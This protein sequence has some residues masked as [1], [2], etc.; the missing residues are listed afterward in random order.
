MK[1]IYLYNKGRHA[2]HIKGFCIHGKS[3]K[4]TGY[5]PFETENDIIT[6]YGKSVSWCKNCLKKREQKME[7][8]K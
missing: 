2:L 8:L 5:I 3:S 6:E 1:D 4:A 7:E